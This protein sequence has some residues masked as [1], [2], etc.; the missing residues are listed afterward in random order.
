MSTTISKIGGLLIKGSMKELKKKNW[1][2]QS[3]VARHYLDLKPWWL[4]L[5][6]VLMPK[7]LRM[8]FTSVRHLLIKKS[9]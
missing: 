5:M 7:H 2:I 6:E 8:L 9:K 3:T 4:K 1:I